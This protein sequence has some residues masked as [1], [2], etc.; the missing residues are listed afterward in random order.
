MIPS[1]TTFGTKGLPYFGGKSIDFSGR[2]AAITEVEADFN[3]LMATVKKYT[4]PGNELVLHN[5]GIALE[6]AWGLGLKAV[7][8]IPVVNA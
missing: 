7:A 8:G 5:F 1:T 6:Q 3:N 4:V 2:A